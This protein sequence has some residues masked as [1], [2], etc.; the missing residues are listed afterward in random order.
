MAQITD[1]IYRLKADGSQLSKQLKKSRKGIAAFGQKARRALN[2]AGK[3][4]IGMGAGIAAMTLK[5][6]EGVDSLQKIADASGLASEDMGALQLAAELGGSSIDKFGKGMGRLSRNI[7]DLQRGVGESRRAFEEYDIA[8]SNADGT[9]RSTL[10][11]TKDI[12]DRIQEMGP[13]VKSTALA[14]ESFGRAGQDLM[15]MLLQGSEGIEQMR[16]EADAMGLTFDE[17]AG[18]A[19]EKFN[20]DLARLKITQRGIFR[21]LSIQLIPVVQLYADSLLEA[22][23]GSSALETSVSGLSQFFKGLLA[24]LESIISAFKIWATMVELPFKVMAAALVGMMDNID[25]AGKVIDAFFSAIVDRDLTKLKN[26]DVLGDIEANAERTAGNI[27]GAFTETFDE[28]EKEAGDLVDKWDSIFNP[29]QQGDVMNNGDGGGGGGGAS[30]FTIDGTVLES[31]RALGRMV[32]GTADRI[33]QAAEAHEEWLES[34]R[35]EGRRVFSSTRTELE[36]VQIEV[37]RLNLL[38]SQ[39]AVDTDTYIRAMRQ[40]TA[41]LR[42]V[43]EEAKDAAISFDES[44]EQ[45]KSFSD[46]MQDLGRGAAKSLF[47]QFETALFN[48]LEQSL[49]Q[50]V[51]NFAQAVGRMALEAAAAGLLQKLFSPNA[52]IPGLDLGPGFASGGFVRGPGTATSDSIPAR[53]SDGEYVVRAQAVR[54]VGVSTLDQINRMSG[55]QNFAQGGMATAGGGGNVTVANFVSEEAMES[56]LT[57][58]PGER[59]I[60]NV[61]R[62]FGGQR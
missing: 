27:A 36:N 17:K 2:I 31:W 39:G 54:S 48:P 51:A 21:Q 28:I 19:A 46:Q 56:F 14:M 49:E 3:A 15:P 22:R 52:G 53:L 24:T 23:D 18:R 61:V 38:F 62:R 20:D 35:A 16:K 41:P 55:P 32:V 44:G 4:A 11:V 7:Q 5:A 13:G 25:I 47:S 9:I 10:D 8:A 50:M 40:A 26:L 34:L 58:R 33:R 60:Q 6:N 37:D 29:I 57:S 1:L 42:D 12:A 59:I 45:V 30:P 43:K